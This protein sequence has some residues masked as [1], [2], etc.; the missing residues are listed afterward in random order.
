MKKCLAK[1]ITNNGF[2]KLCIERNSLNGAWNIR[3]TKWNPQITYYDFS[4]WSLKG[5]EI[6][7]ENFLKDYMAKENK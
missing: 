7:V 5:V 4:D 1:L 2:D 6:K 3:I